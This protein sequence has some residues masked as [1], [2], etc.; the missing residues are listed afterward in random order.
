MLP[1]TPQ[2]RPWRATEAVVFDEER[3]E[4]RWAG[5]TARHIGTVVH[6]VLQQIADEG[7]EEWISRRSEGLGDY[8]HRMLAMLGVSA[9]ALD[10]ATARARAAIENC[11]ADE[12]GRWIVAPHDD[13][14]SEYALSGWL[15][16]KLRNMVIDRTFVED[17]R[18]WIIDYKT[19][20]HEGGTVDAFLDGEMERYLG[21]LERYARVM[22]RMDPMPIELGLYFPMVQGWRAWTYRG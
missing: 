20:S 9:G 6:C 7:T 14:R 5:E 22:Q 17:G 15:D 2:L 3:I 16:G 1:E 4:F 10:D 11:I 12:R 13:A 18:R 21:Q 19:G 8:L